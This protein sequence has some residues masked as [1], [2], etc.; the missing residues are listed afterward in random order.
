MKKLLM[1]TLTLFLTS[2]CGITEGLNK[3]CGS[4]LE[5]FCNLTFGYKDKDQDKE[6]ADNTFKNN[7][8][9]ARLKA[10]EEQNEQLI[11]SMDAFSLEIEAL[12]LT[13]TT[14]RQ[15]F[16]T[17]I[18]SLTTTVNANLVTLN[19]LATSVNSNGSVTKMIDVCGDKSG[20]YDE[21][22][23]KTNTGKYIAYF[24]DG[25]KRFLTEISN[26]GYV[27]TDKQACSFTI[28]SSGLTHV[29]NGVTRI[30]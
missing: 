17:L 29:V 24:E 28:S 8:Q 18:N 3:N 11:E 15:Y 23:L 26:G 19:N 22:I 25:G 16:Q 5:E 6:I 9:D 20:Y 7:E 14:N 12:E 4:D 27:T 21:I 2:S 30:D 10:L 1:I 13:D